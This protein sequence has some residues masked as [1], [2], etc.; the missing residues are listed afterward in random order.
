MKKKHPPN[1]QLVKKYLKGSSFSNIKRSNRKNKKI[2]ATY[3][4]GKVYHA[5]HINYEDF[6]THK[7][8]KRRLN[9]CKRSS[10]IKNPTPANLLARVGLWNC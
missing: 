7:D 4:D 3:K 6:T 10:K 2:Q 1:M 5:G 8:N 9:Y